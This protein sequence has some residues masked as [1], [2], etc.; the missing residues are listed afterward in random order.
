[1][2]NK[3]T[4]LHDGTYGKVRETVL[5]AKNKVYAAVNSATV[6][7]DVPNSRHTVSRIELVTLSLAYAD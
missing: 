2:D 4:T 1:M 6:L 5:T 3:M 7:C